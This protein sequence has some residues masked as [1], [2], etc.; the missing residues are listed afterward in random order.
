[1]IRGALKS[2][3]RLSQA[4]S[5]GRIYS[6]NYLRAH[7]P[8]GLHGAWSTRGTAMMSQTECVMIHLEQIS[9]MC[10]V[11]E[12]LV[13]V[14]AHE[15]AMQC[16]EWMDRGGGGAVRCCSALNATHRMFSSCPALP[17]QCFN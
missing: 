6:G 1:M 17:T 16:F 2:Q 15:R 4:L 11:L 7:T 9:S 3:I 8:E 13:S 12:P 14:S 10:D 5:H